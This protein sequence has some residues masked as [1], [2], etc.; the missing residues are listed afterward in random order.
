MQLIL[1]CIW[2]SFPILL[3]NTIQECRI[4][5]IRYCRRCIN[6]LG[7]HCNN[8]TSH[9]VKHTPKINLINDMHMY[10]C[11]MRNM[12]ARCNED[13]KVV[14]LRYSS[15]S[16]GY[17]IVKQ[18]DGRLI[19]MQDNFACPVKQPDSRLFNRPITYHAPLC[20]RSAGLSLEYRLINRRPVD[21][22]T[23]HAEHI[24]THTCTYVH[25]PFI[26]VAKNTPV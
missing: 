10:A 8:L 23:I 3:S 18:P 26:H 16:I 7:N 12:K 4:I 15:T 2:S 22:L 13:W 21:K 9:L 19:N 17:H 25:T 5:F 24:L 1:I 6:N 11:R 14:H 20:I